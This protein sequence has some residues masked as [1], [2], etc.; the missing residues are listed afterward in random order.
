MRQTAKIISGLALLGT[1]APPFL[2]FGG[3]LDLDPVKSWMLAAT[4]VWF[5]ATPLWMERR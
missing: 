2:Y 1:I 5:A 4:A 3:R